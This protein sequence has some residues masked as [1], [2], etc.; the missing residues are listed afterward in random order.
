MCYILFLSF[1][2]LLLCIETQPIEKEKDENIFKVIICV[3]KIRRERVRARVEVY[4]RRYII[5]CALFIRLL[6]YNTYTLRKRRKKNKIF[7]SL[8]LTELDAV[9]IMVVF[10]Y[11]L[12]DVG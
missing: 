12:Y 5:L 11:N 3:L 9:V 8:L 1:F 2:L 7:Y 6:C 4:G 10:V